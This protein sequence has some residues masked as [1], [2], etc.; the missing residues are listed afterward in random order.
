M[1]ASRLI[2]ERSTVPSFFGISCPIANATR[3]DT[4]TAISTVKNVEKKDDKIKVNIPY[5]G[6]SAEEF[7]TGPRRNSFHPTFAMEGPPLAIINIPINIT[8]RKVINAKE[9][10]V[11]LKTLSD[12]FFFRVFI[13]APSIICF[14]HCHRTVPKQIHYSDIDTSHSIVYFLIGDILC[15]SAIYFVTV[16]EQ[17]AVKLPSFVVTVITAVPAFLAVMTPVEDTFATDVFEDF[18]VTFWLEA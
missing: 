12:K 8:D 9:K 15:G 10:T 13:P 14:W 18:Q 2:N 4:G 6:G 16:T 3:I 17:V 5:S 1:P 11:A 7:Q